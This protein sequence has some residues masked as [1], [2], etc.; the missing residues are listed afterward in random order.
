LRSAACPR[1]ISIISGFSLDQLK[2][3]TQKPSILRTVFGNSVMFMLGFSITFISLGASASWLGQ[4]L[5]SKMPLLYKIAGV[6]IIIF[7]LHLLGIFRI[8]FLYRD[9]RFHNV[10][11]PRGVWGALV[12]GLAF[13]FGWTP[14]I[15]TILAG[16]LAIA[17]TKQTVTQGIF[18][19][20]VYS[21]G[22]GIPF[23]MTSLGLNQFLAFY[24]R[25]KRHFRTVEMASGA[26]VIAVGVLVLTNSLSRLAAWFSFLNRFAL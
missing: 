10:D 25:F 18:L 21:L 16:I 22:L 1:Y 2:I 7:G 23:L 24:S 15:G 6:I 4:V 8:N 17:S 12:L 5:L 3:E 9:K 11:K 19:L 14:C 13:A 20:A 26:L